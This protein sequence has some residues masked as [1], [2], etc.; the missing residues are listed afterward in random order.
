MTPGRNFWRRASVHQGLLGGLTGWEYRAFLCGDENVLE[1][2]RGSGGPT[3][4]TYQVPT[5]AALSDAN[6]TVL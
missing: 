1:S 4:G 5:N 3:L 2:E 6:L